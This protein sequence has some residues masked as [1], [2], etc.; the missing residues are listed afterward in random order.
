MKVNTA[1]H[2]LNLLHSFAHFTFKISITKLN[3]NIAASRL[4]VLHL[5]ACFTAVPDY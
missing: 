5:F 2:Q 4:I 1:A 3:V